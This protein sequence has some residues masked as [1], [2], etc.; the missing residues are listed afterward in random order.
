MKKMTNWE[1]LQWRGLVKDVAGENI[2][3]LINNK[4]VT[5]YWGTDPT[6]D[7]LHLG[8]YSSLVTA[9][10]LMK[11]GHKPILL[12]GGAT[13]RIGDPR[14]TAEREI[15]SIEVLNHNIECIRKQIDTIFDGNAKLVNNYDWFKGYEF[16]DFLRDVGKYINVNYML[17]KDI[18]NRR[19]ETG[20]TYAEFSYMLIQGYDFLNMYRKM[21]CVMQVEG[22][23]Q[24]GNITTGIDLIRKIDGK[25]AYAFTMPLILDSNGKKF[26]KS[27]GNALWLDKDKTSS[28]ALYQYLINTDDAKV[29][30]YLKVFTFLTPEEIL[31]VMDR[32]NKEPH[33]RIAQETLAKCIITDLRGEEEYTKARDISKALFSEDIKNLSSEDIV[34]SLSG[35]KN[36]LVYEGN[37]VD[38]LVDSKVFSSKREARELITGNALSINNKK[39]NDVNYIISKNDLIDNKIVVIKKGK[40]NY[41]IG[42]F[43]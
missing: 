29:L 31:D 32:H 30:E 28:Y 37:I 38:V 43:N 1:E 11:M 5:F 15:I 20:I 40:K 22:S 2:E 27:E 13:G 17:N 18:I 26:G 12:C 21:N 35:V 23:D 8:H 9:K 42:K 7:S 4:S 39:V 19:L 16:L 41:F 14:P 6:A 3:D 36:V 10:R 34:N 33:L 25:E 24:W